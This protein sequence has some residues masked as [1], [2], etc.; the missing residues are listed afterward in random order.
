MNNKVLIA[1]N[2]K[3]MCQLISMALEMEEIQA[4]S[5]YSGKEALQKLAEEQFDVVIS[6]L[7]MSPVDGLTLLKEVKRNYPNVEFLIMTAYASQETA[8][9]AMKM[10]AHDYLI[11]PFEMDE[12]V[13]RVKRLLEQLKMKEEYVHLKAVK[14]EKIQ[15]RQIVGKSSSM[16]KVY[17]LIEKIKNTEATVLI[18]GESGTG[19]EL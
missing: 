9:E 18:H 15:Y 2:E 5:V 17:N 12:M 13:I 4:V 6:D 11:K 19:K 16:Q 14:E 7:K 1:D 10:G 8:L 3:K